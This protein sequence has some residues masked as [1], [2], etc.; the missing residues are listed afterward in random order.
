VVV[1]RRQFGQKLISQE[2]PLGLGVSSH[3]PAAPSLLSIW[4]LDGGREEDG[5]LAIVRRAGGRV[6]AIGLPHHL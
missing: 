5:T 6:G 2:S 1:A 4:L 3:L